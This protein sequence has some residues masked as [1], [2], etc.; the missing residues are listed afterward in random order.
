MTVA[1]RRNMRCTLQNFSNLAGKGFILG[2]AF[3]DLNLGDLTR[4]IDVNAQVNRLTAVWQEQDRTKVWGRDRQ[5]GAVNMGVNLRCGGL[6]QPRLRGLGG[7]WLGPCAWIVNRLGTGR[8]FRWGRCVQQWLWVHRKRGQPRRDVWRKPSHHHQF[9]GDGFGHGR[10]GRFSEPRQ[11]P[12]DGMQHQG[13][14]DAPCARATV[15]QRS[16]SRAS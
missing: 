2:G 3:D 15:N 13:A 10:G 12:P 5:G 4:F 1:A 11:F 14:G 7:L 6:Y 8:G 16:K 9:T